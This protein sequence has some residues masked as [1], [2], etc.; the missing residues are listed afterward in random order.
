MPDST[1]QRGT[2]ALLIDLDPDGT[3]PPF[4]Q[5][6]V[7]L[8]AL[9]EE[10]VRAPGHRLP[11]VRRLAGHLGVAP[12]TVARAYREPEQAGVLETRG[13]HGTFGAGDQRAYARTAAETGYSTKRTIELRVQIVRNEAPGTG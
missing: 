9:V 8:A 7:R 5:I 1:T 13:R 6:R 4:R 10:G 2:F 11:A 3:I 12:G